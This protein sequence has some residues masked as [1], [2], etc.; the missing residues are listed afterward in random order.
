MARKRGLKILIL[1]V[2]AAAAAAA[3]WFWSQRPSQGQ[4]IQGRPEMVTRG[5]VRHLVV[6]TGTVKP[7]VGA[8]VKVGARVSGR[9]EKLL[10]SIGQKVK[11]GEVVAVI[12]H[13]DLVARLEQAKAE[14]AADQARLQRVLTTGPKEIARAEADLGEARATVEFTAL[15]FKRQ[16]QM[17]QGDLVA[18]DALDRAR[19]RHLVAQARLAAAK[20]RL[21]QVQQSFQQDLKVA[22]ADLAAARARLATTQVNLDYATVRAPISGVVSSV[23][24][25][26][27]E[28]VAASLSAPTFITIVD[29][30]RLQVDDFVDETDIGRVKLG[31]EA[32]FTVD[33][34]PGRTFL[35][36]VDAIQP[37]AKIVDDVVYYDVVI[38]ILVKYQGLLKPEMTA[39]VS[40]VTGVRSNALTVP[41]E[42]VRQRGGRGL[43]YLREGDQVRSQP[44][45]VGW[46]EAG[47]VEIL[48]G[49]QEGQVVIVPKAPPLQGMNG[50]R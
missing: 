3:W 7:Q 42:A 11:A 25:Q 38:K 15:D 10:V 4:Q 48:K 24:T 16:Q 5:T 18:Q 36:R 35:G 46:S 43:V 33:A 29:L 21:A 27:G 20:A 44:V 1:V 14:L 6:S 34:Y 22:Q 8:E 40:I 45:L 9:V 12:E 49:L 13:K 41:A 47:R 19:E 30:S 23:S 2:L 50:R 17:R 32:T 28:T 37:S 31:Q 26:E 39:T